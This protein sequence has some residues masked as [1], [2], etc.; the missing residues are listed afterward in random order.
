MEEITTARA[1]NPTKGQ[2][3]RIQ[4]AHLGKILFGLQFVSLVL[5]LAGLLSGLLAV[6][7]YVLLALISLLTIFLIYAAYPEF[8]SW[9]GGGDALL[10][11]SDGILRATPY[12]ASITLALS[13]LSIALL[14]CDFRKKSIP[15]I[16]VSA[17]VAVIAIV[18][19][20]IFYVGGSA[21]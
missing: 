17:I 2:S 13:L 11:I 20:A 1:Y 5:I 14:C 7:Y 4:L 16:V 19:L 8:A 15:R 9:W 18:A 3:A 6:T 10:R 21:A 12:T